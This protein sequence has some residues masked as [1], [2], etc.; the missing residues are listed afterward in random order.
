MAFRLL[1]N[2]VKQW[3]VVI[4]AFA[5]AATFWLFNSLN[6]EYTTSLNYPVAFV[7]NQDSLISVRSLP[8]SIDLDVTGGGWSL[9]RKEPIFSPDPVKI[10]LS[11]PVGVR[12]LSWSQVL[13]S[14]KSQIEELSINRVFQDTLRIQIEPRINKK[15]KLWVDSTRINMKDN[16]RIVSSVSMPRDSIVLTGPKSFIDTLGATY[17][18]QIVEDRIDEDFDENVALIVPRPDLISA[19]PSSVRTIFSVDRFDQLQIEVIVD[20][21]NFPSDSS[22]RLA[23][24]KVTLHFTVRRSL[25]QDYSMADF[26]VSADYN[27]LRSSDSSVLVELLHFPEEIG[28]IEVRPKQLRVIANE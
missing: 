7:Y 11:N 24:E 26:G 12:H 19:E 20:P 5:V 22:Y 14:I 3:K 10:D 18:L 21:I 16:F 9:L 13:P 17:E 4:L 15:V 6:K 1:P 23:E 28:E 27:I 8:S 2:N 25:E